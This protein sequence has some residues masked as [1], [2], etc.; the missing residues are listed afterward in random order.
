MIETPSEIL[1]HHAD[2][3]ACDSFIAWRRKIKKPLTERG[4]VM[5]AKTLAA[6]NAAGGDATEALD[7]AQ[8]HGWSTIKADWYFK[9]RPK[10]MPVAQTDNRMARFAEF[11]RSGKA[12]MCRDIPA[13]YAREMVRRGVVT[14][15]QCR[16][17]GV[18]L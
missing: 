18:V 17:A 15:D 16:R 14:E 1:A 12:F 4:A 11:I 8:E 13:T 2:R 9:Q 3:D 7:M 6:I 5:I 10:P